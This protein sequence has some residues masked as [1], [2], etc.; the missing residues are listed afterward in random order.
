MPD[1]IDLHMHTTCSDGK[2]TPAELLAL[3]RESGIAAFAVTDHDTLDGYRE[4][5]RLLQAGD[6]ELIT[7]VELSATMGPRDAHLLAYLFDP[8]NAEFNSALDSFRGQRVER[9]HRILEKLAELGLDVPF[10]EV[11]K[12]SGDGVIG[13]P[14][15]AE[16]MAAVGAV[17]NYEEAF[18]KYIHN[19]GPAYVPK[20]RM[21]PEQAISLVHAAGGIVVLAHPFLDQMYTHVE[22]LV[23]LGLDG[24]EIYHYMHTKAEIKRAADLARTYKLVT[25]GGSDFHGREN[26]SGNIGSTRVPS[27]L[28][29]SLKT[30]ARLRRGPH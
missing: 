5:R 19:D 1:T 15:I 12:A 13:R 7:G 6:P 28:L 16:A 30:R 2:K 22:Y 3:V 4:V 10:A 8:D 20:A 9:G 11:E 25:S 27:D 24:I 14:H 29:E 17:R 26:R 23:G 21:T 18:R